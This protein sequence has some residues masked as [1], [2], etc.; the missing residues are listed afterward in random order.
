M[1]DSVNEVKAQPRAIRNVIHLLQP[2]L[3]IDAQNARRLYADIAWWGVLNGIATSFLSVFVLRLGGSD[4]HV[5]LLTALPALV[6]VFFSIPGSR[7]IEREHKPLSVLL[8]SGTLNRAGYLA[9]ALLPFLL[10]T[11]AADGVV[12]LVGLLS[13]PAAVSNVA[14]TTM[15]GRAVKPEHRAH[16]VSIRSVWVGIT[17]TLAAFLGGLFLELVIFPINYQILFALAFAASMVSIY[18]LSRIRLPEAA[19]VRAPA[20]A[21]SPRGVRA[22]INLLRSNDGYVR[23]ALTSFV[24]QWGVYF[25]TPLYSI[26]WV[27]N[28]DA[29]DGWVGVINMVGSATTILFY[30]LWGRLTARRG[31][32][33]AMILTTAGMAGYP[34]FLALAPSVEWAVVVS[35]WGGVVSS[36]QALSFFNGLLEVCPELNRSSYIA[37]YNTLVN[38]AAF[39]AP[40]LSTSLTELSSI[41]AMLFLGA[42]LRLLGSFLIWRKRALVP[43]RVAA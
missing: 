9:I 31:N 39:A 8:I 33:I 42:G 35:F 36:G 12:L 20:R 30:P 18:H 5:G 40:I 16:V 14:F 28:L 26:Y 6:A 37:G 24:F 7:L 38:I 29:S 27:R 17:S 10:A 1:E 25:T 32:R 11:R 15:F 43:E 13:I 4:T 2:P 34:F 21:R 41:Q 22:L 3:T 19:S 23:F